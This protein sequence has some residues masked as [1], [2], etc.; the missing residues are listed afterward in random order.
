[1]SKL[2]VIIQITQLLSQNQCTYDDTE[3]ILQCLL[4]HYKTVREQKEYATVQ[5]FISNKKSIDIG[6]K[7]VSALKL[8]N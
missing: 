7:V 5:D 3:E 4:G 6:N 1:M 8:L 2:S